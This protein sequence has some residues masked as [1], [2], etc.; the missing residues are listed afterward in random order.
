MK[1]WL[2]ILLNA[3]AWLAKHI[4]EKKGNETP[5]PTKKK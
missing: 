5:K 4:L 1:Q 3:V 2:K